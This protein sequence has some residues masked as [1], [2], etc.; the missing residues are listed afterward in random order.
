MP[1]AKKFNILTDM[2]KILSLITL[3]NVTKESYA[4]QRLLCTKLMK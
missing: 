3:L 2:K 4:I 1:A